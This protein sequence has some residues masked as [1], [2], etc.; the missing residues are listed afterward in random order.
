MPHFSF[1]AVG[2]L[3][4][5]RACA[6]FQTLSYCMD[7]WTNPVLTCSTWKVWPELLSSLL[8]YVHCTEWL[9][10]FLYKLQL[11]MG[12]AGTAR[13]SK[14]QSKLGMGKPSIY[15]FPFLLPILPISER[16]W[17]KAW[18]FLMWMRYFDIAAEGAD[19]TNS[20]ILNSGKQQSC[21]RLTSA[22]GEASLDQ[23]GN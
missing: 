2:P 18:C 16:K 4:L 13:G 23:A 11:W 7:I 17:A 14:E 19:Q 9:K 20:A 3:C 6:D 21:M 5:S 8:L 10:P 1:R 12:Y 15:P 22:S